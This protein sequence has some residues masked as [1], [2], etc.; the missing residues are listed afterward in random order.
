MQF[1][2]QLAE[3]LAEG[4]RYLGSGKDSKH[5]VDHE[6]MNILVRNGA[7]RRTSNS[8]GVVEVVHSGMIFIH[9][10]LSSCPGRMH[11]MRCSRTVH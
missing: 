7:E 10:C 6:K 3:I 5:Y 8:Q 1:R 9:N 11:M 2:E 4:R